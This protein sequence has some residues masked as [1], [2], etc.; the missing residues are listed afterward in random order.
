MSESSNN[1]AE[2]LRARDYKEA[3]KAA[4]N[5]FEDDYTLRDLPRLEDKDEDE[6]LSNEL[7][8]KVVS[9]EKEKI[10]NLPELEKNSEDDLI[11]EN[12]FKE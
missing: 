5:F 10:N 9:I 2:V 6:D 8:I 4:K 3:L 11:E 1:S 12:R 7:A